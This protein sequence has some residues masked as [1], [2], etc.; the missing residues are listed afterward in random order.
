MKENEFERLNALADQLNSRCD[1]WFDSPAMVEFK[2]LLQRASALLPDSYSLEL[3]VELRVLDEPRR[4]F[5]RMLTAGLGCNAG[6]P[7]F[8]CSGDSTPQRYIVD[9]ELC[10]IPH[11]YCPRCWGDWDFK[12]DNPQCPDCGCRLGPDLKILL[13]RDTCPRCEKATVSFHKPTCPRC[14][15]FVNPEYVSWG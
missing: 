10:E 3:S 13:D 6:Q 14:G 8:R 11:D 1:E 9:G 2:K 15:F 5:V 12:F 7:P 4:G